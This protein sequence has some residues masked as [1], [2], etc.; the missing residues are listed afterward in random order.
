MRG[1]LQLYPMKRKINERN[2]N[3]RIDMKLLLFL[4]IAQLALTTVTFAAETQ[5]SPSSSKNR[6]FIIIVTENAGI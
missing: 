3:K 2:T 4:T 1:H 5:T 6:E